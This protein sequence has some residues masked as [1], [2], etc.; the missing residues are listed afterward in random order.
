MFSA[1]SPLPDNLS[2]YEFAGLLAGRRLA[3]TKCLTNDLLIPAEADFVIEGYT[4]LGETR[5]EGPFGDHFGY[6]SLAEEYPILHITAITHRRNA[7]FPATIVG[8]PPM[9][10]GFLGEAIGEAFLSVLQFQ[11]RDVVDLFLPLETGFH[12]LAIVASRQRYP[13]QARKTALGLLGAG[14]MMFLKSIVATDADHSVKDLDALLDALDSKVNIAHDIQILTVKSP[15]HWLM[16]RLGIMSIRRSS[17]T[18]PRRPSTTLKALPI[19]PRD[20]GMVLPKSLAWLTA[21]LLFGCCG[22]RCS[23]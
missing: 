18:P 22:P 8:L 5:L 14:Q 16:L 15:T 1:I 2:E 11:H 23:W 21:F 17:S 20:R 13:R 19:S 12:N 3:L 10:D 9:E 7:V 6:Y 4:T